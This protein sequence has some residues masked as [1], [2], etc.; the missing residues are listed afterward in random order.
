MQGA[1]RQNGL[2]GVGAGCPDPRP[3]WHSHALA[4]PHA[5]P[6]RSGGPGRRGRCRGRGHGPGARWWKRRQHARRS[7][8][9][10]GQDP[11]G[12]SRPPR[13]RIRRGRG[14]RTRAVSRP[15]PRC[16]NRRGWQLPPPTTHHSGGGGGSACAR[17]A[18]RDAHPAGQHSRCCCCRG[19]RAHAGASPA[20]RRRRRRR[21]ARPDWQG[22]VRGIVGGGRDHA[23]AHRQAGGDFNFAD[24]SCSVSSRHPQQDNPRRQRRQ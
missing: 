9:A 2:P 7:G 14:Q 12:H 4:R 8:K 24:C 23:R 22:W 1:A 18:A 6:G 17:G 16:Y 5:G 21:H 13:G 11:V 10:A 20:W 19:R 15:G 3:Q